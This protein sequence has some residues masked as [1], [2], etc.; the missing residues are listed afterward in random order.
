MSEGLARPDALLRL[1]QAPGAAPPPYPSAHWISYGGGEGI[2]LAIVLLAVAG[3]FAY[4]GK[5]LRT[6]LRVTPPGGVVTAFMIAIWLL[7]IC[8]MLVATFVYGLQVKQAY[9]SFV[10]ARVRVGTFVDALVTFFVI[11]YL[12]RRWGWKVALASAVIGTAA[13]PWIFE[14]PFD[15]IIMTR[16]N[17]PLPTYPMLYR[18][19]FFLPLFL[20]GFSTVSLLT[21]LPSVRVTAYASYA[22]A[23]MFAVLAVWA[24]FGF[25]FPAEPLP[26]VLNV[27]SKILS[28][29]AAIMLFVW[30]TD[31][32][33]SGARA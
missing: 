28:F 17:P 10:A 6:P 7:A 27:I 19:M 33:V 11:L 30:G 16:T 13:A 29:V 9:P 12:T 20:V 1:A 8:N 15:L 5:R 4:A 14:F 24:A 25:A 32:Q 22:V 18:Q 23:G 21:L 2:L 26:L 3:G 31:G